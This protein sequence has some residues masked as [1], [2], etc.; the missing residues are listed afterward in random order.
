MVKTQLLS[1][2]CGWWRS[3]D[4]RDSGWLAAHVMRT[5]ELL[6]LA[7]AV[8]AS[9]A[10][11]NEEDTPP[12][13]SESDP[14]HVALPSGGAATLRAETVWQSD[15]HYD[16]PH[17]G[18]VVIESARP[19]MTEGLAS[20]ADADLLPGEQVPGVG[21]VLEPDEKGWF[22]GLYSV[23][24]D[25]DGRDQRN[26]RAASGLRTHWAS[27]LT[28]WNGSSAQLKVDVR[29]VASSYDSE[30]RRPDLWVYPP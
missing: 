8:A 13:R 19:P 7:A 29:A 27:Y 11:E 20:L 14:V 25:P 4:D 5:V 26:E 12:Q 9:L 16:V 10:T 3:L 15:L 17:V 24:L 2:R 22:D 6:A 23:P 30:P 28:L 1:G 21:L 18:L